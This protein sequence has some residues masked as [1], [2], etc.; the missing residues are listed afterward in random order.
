MFCGIAKHAAQS[1][2]LNFSYNRMFL[3]IVHACDIFLLITISLAVGG[4]GGY[5]VVVSTAAFHARVR[6]SFPGL[7]SLEETKIFLS[8]PLVKLNI[9]EGLR[10]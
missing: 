6:C 9:V 10:D 1:N 7:S 2:A 4:G 8:H 5:R 3:I